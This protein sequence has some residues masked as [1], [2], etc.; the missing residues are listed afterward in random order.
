M[1]YHWD[2]AGCETIV[3]YRC[4]AEAACTSTDSGGANRVEFRRAGGV[5]LLTQPEPVVVHL[6]VPKW[7]QAVITSVIAE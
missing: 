3:T 4:P 5:R 1:T 2:V 7:S 6:Q